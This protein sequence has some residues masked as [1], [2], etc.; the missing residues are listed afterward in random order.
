VI[1]E[2]TEKYNVEAGIKKLAL[3]FKLMQKSGQAGCIYG[4]RAD[5]IPHTDGERGLY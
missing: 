2:E 3:R 5:S 4:N 1:L